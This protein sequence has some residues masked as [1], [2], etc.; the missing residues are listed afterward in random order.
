MALR[1]ARR[2]V[3]RG[4]PPGRAAG[5]YGAIQAQAASLQVGGVDSDAHGSPAMAPRNPVSQEGNFSNSLSGKTR[6]KPEAKGGDPY[7]GK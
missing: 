4:R 2:S 6:K 7:A 5:R 1:T 3:V